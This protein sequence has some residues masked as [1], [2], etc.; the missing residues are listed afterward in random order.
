MVA[1]KWHRLIERPVAA[2][3]RAFAR[4]DLADEIAAT[5]LQQFQTFVLGDMM[6]PGAA[7]DLGNWA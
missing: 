1:I 3:A 2:T 7:A 5:G 6:V 4:G